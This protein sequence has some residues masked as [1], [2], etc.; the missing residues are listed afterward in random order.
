MAPRVAS[1]LAGDAEP[2]PSGGTDSVLSVYQA[3]ATADRPI[4]VAVGNDGMW[5]R[6]CGVL[7]CP[8]LAADPALATNAGRRAARPRI[9]PVVAERLARAPAD[10]WLARLA[11]AG[12]PAAPIQFLGQVVADR[13][14]VARGAITTLQHPEAGPVRVVQSPWRLDGVPGAEVA[15]RPPPR[16]GEHSREVLREVGYG[17]AEIDRLAATGVTQE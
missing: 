5:R 2:P 13:Q 9:L 17:E 14:V 1:L 6:L 11:A 8:E 3:F 16:L 7:D 10:A 4:V 15:H 12:I